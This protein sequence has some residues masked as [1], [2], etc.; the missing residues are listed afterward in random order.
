M[1]N[2][3]MDVDGNKYCKS[4]MIKLNKQIE[5]NKKEYN[6]NYNKK[7]Y[8]EEKEL[9][10]FYNSKEWKYIRKVVLIRDNYCCCNCLKDGRI[11][12]AETVHHKVELKD[13][14]ELRL[15]TTNLV[16]LCNKCHNK[17]HNRW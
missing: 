8:E 11:T 5:K 4:C 3:L 13:A 16:S 7:R 17:I 10:R 2:R 9:Y 15:D 14:W 1:C 6:K 12:K